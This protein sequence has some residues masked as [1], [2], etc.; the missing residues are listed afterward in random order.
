MP[1]FNETFSPKY[2]I[3]AKI[4]KHLG[5]ELNDRKNR[6]DKSDILEQALEAITGGKL[7]WVDEKGYDHFCP[8][9][10]YKAEMK[11][12]SCALFTKKLKNKKKKVSLK[13]VNTLQNKEEKKKL[14]LT[15]DDLI[16]V[17]SFHGAVGIVPYS[18]A[19][20]HSIEV[21]DGF[22]TEI[23][24]EKVHILFEGITRTPLINNVGSYSQQKKKM[25]KDY[26]QS[27]FS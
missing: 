24:L 1:S 10:N 23:P 12:G 4:C 18:V 7:Q 17:D 26:I 13:L 14:E 25:Q 21:S 5:T 6:F 20:E 2:E 27:F 16:I 22:K 3:L 11:T 8:E 19:I 9:L 15:A